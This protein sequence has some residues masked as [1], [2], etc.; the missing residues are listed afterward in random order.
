M[1]EAKAVQHSN[2][3]FR[4]D[5]SYLTFLSNL[6]IWQITAEKIS[7][8]QKVLASCSNTCDT[9]HAPSRPSSIYWKL[10]SF[11]RMSIPS[12]QAEFQSRNPT[13]KYSSTPAKETVI[14]SDEEGDSQLRRRGNTSEPSRKDAPVSSDD[15][16]IL[17]EKK[18]HFC[19]LIF[20]NQ[21][22]SIEKLSRSLPQATDNLGGFLDSLLANLP[23]RFVW[24]I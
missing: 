12:S 2:F 20:Y 4:K 21:F 24:C 16:E 13:N 11:F 18:Y 22:F 9:I 23:S 1:S 17:N 8:S 19:L 5:M 7:F 3:S 14:S 6:L 10:V 15:D